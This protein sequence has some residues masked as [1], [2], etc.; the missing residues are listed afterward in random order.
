MLTNNK[1][2]EGYP[3]L[4]G[5]SFDNTISWTVAGPTPEVASHSSISW[6]MPQRVLQGL[7][8]GLQLLKF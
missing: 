3:D 1:N 4:L 7:N 5:L 6:R 2:P 8:E